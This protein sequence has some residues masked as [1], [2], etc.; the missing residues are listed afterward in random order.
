MKTT[1][2]TRIATFM[3]AFGLLAAAQAELSIPAFTAYTEP[4]SNG[5]TISKEKGITHWT[6]KK[7][8]VLWFGEIKSS[9]KLTA[10]IKA[11]GAEGHNLRLTIGTHIKRG[12]KV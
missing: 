4:D 12:S 5:V 9:G 8:R 11:K 3:A 7:Q 10:V 1:P 2:L 6:D